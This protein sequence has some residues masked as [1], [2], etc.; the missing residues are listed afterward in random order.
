MSRLVPAV[1]RAFDILELFLGERRALTAPEVATRLGLPRST[2]HELLNTLVARA[3]L[4]RRPPVDGPYRLGPRLLELGSRYQQDLDLAVEG[5]LVARE[6]AAEC[7]ETVHVAVLDGTDVVYVCKID[8]MHSVR[9]V[10]AVGRRIPAHC[11][12]VG[13]VLLAGLPRQQLDELFRGRELAGLTGRSI[14]SL[15]ALRGELAEIRRNGVGYEMCESNPDV[16]CVAAPVTDT[17]GEW[18]AALS[19]SVPTIRHTDESW[20]RWEKLVRDGAGELSRALGSRV[21]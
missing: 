14:T 7:G 9:M 21:R 17:T 18:V 1:T 8:S 16:G 5:E 3:Y 11:T 10:S 19:I 20:P 13:K 4:V 15:A 12:A 6:I 2:T